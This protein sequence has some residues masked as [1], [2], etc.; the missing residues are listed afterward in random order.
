MD[1]TILKEHL[2]QV[3]GIEDEETADSL[4]KSIVGH[5][6][7]R[8]SEPV[9]VKITAKLPQPLTYNRLRG[10]QIGVTTISKEQYIEDVC[11]QFGLEEKTVEEASH[12]V[13]HEIKAEFSSDEIHAWEQ[14]MPKG[15]VE[16]V[17]SA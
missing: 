1:Y 14:E 2:L 16:M 12:I 17:E 15:W 11:E 5:L 9:A 8:V 3:E 6:V 13:L 10:H 7:S 4:I